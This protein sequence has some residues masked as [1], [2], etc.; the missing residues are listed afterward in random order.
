[1][2]QFTRLLQGN[3]RSLFAHD[4]DSHHQAPTDVLMSSDGHEQLLIPYTVAYEREHFDARAHVGRR[5][6][7]GR[8]P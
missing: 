6:A 4:M 3:G 1:M 5:K 8:W 2:L 7:L